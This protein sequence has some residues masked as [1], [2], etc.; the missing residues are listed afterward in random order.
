MPQAVCVRELLEFSLIPQ[1]M[2][3]DR[4]ILHSDMPTCKN[5]LIGKDS[6]SLGRHAPW[7]CIRMVFHSSVPLTII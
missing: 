2:L 4:K 1:K 7:L 6:I 5:G 3:E